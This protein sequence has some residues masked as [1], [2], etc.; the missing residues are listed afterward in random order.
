[1]FLWTYILFIT[2]VHLS[3]LVGLTF[4]DRIN[5]LMDFCPVLLHFNNNPHVSWLSVWHIQYV[6]KNKQVWWSTCC[7]GEQTE[8]ISC[9]HLWTASLFSFPVLSECNNAA[10]WW[11]RGSCCCL[12]WQ[13]FFF[14]RWLFFILNDQSKTNK[15]YHLKGICL[16]LSNCIM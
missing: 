6:P 7:H 12:I 1:M 3:E 14:Y 4:S 9:H 2:C 13:S 5:D 16:L 10:L 15:K 11:I 8:L